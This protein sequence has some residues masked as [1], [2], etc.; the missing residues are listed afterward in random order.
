M[1]KFHA[2]AKIRIVH[3][4]KKIIKT[5]YK[6]FSQ[7]FFSALRSLKILL[8][9]I[10]NII[11]VKKQSQIINNISNHKSIINHAKVIAHCTFQVRLLNI[12]QINT[13]FLLQST[14]QVLI[15]IIF[16][17]LHLYGHML[18][19]I[20][21]AKNKLYLYTLLRVIACVSR[22][23]NLKDHNY[24]SIHCGLLHKNPNLFF[25]FVHRMR[26]QNVCLVMQV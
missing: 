16:L 5:H 21:L 13:R 11:H 2:C 7:L 20:S 19:T 8:R 12:F 14:S 26:I 15:Q 22:M 24:I 9:I 10:I 1:L 25:R 6:D 4:W 17:N 3:V 23:R 18:K